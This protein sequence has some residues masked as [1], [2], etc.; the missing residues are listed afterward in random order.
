MK[1]IES[2]DNQID[3]TLSKRENLQADISTLEQN[4]KDAEQVIHDAQA[5]NTYT[6]VSPEQANEN[7]RNVIFLKKDLASKKSEFDRLDD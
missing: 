6:P 2:D 4:I 3:A 7:K 1:E 5:E